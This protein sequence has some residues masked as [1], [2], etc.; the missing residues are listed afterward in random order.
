M[1]ELQGGKWCNCILISEFLQIKKLK[2][3]LKEILKC[4]IYDLLIEYFHY[5]NNF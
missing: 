1:Q 3:K 4:L 5:R 2:A